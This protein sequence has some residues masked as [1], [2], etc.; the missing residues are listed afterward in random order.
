MEIQVNTDF[1][2]SCD[3]ETNIGYNVWKGEGEPKAIFQIVHGM[4][5]HIDRYDDFARFLAGNGYVIFGNNHI[6][7]GNS[8]TD[9]QNLGHIGGK[10]GYENMVDDIHT[11]MQ[12]AKEN[13][14][15]LPIILFGHSMG[16]LLVRLFTERWAGEIDGLILCGTSGNN[17]LTSTGL[18]LINTIAAVK[19]WRYRSRFIDNMAFGSYN[20]KIDKKRTKFDWLSV[21]EDNVDNYIADDDCGVMFTLGGFYNLMMTLKLVT[22]KDWGTHLPKNLPVL[23]I[24]GADD[25][26][27]GYKKGV[28]ETANRLRSAGVKKIEL[29]FYEGMRHEILNE[30]EPDEVYEDLLNWSE[31]I[32]T[33][34]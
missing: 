25:P 18:A 5:E 30:N 23:L 1:Y 21:N 15:G 26:V 17:P 16:S 33:G 27:G 4:A 24:S 32:I 20:D 10:N 22:R 14:P 29:K 8:V 19:G 13:Y 28:A 7:H 3:G 34:D 6:G 2:G 31:K 9:R 11:L 12:I